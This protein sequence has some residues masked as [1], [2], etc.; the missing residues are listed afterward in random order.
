MAAPHK[1]SDP[2]L[3]FLQLHAVS[4]QVWY[5][6]RMDISKILGGKFVNM[7]K[8]LAQWASEAYVCGGFLQ[9]GL[10]SRPG[11]IY[12]GCWVVFLQEFLGQGLSSTG[13]A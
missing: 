13:L 9:Q 5:S 10:P 2:D 1:F 6:V 3:T 12:L 11:I 8:I 4:A 7:F